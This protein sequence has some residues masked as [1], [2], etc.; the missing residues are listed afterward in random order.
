MLCT[1]SLRALWSLP[2]LQLCLLLFFWL[3]AAS[4]NPSWHSDGVLSL[5]V[6][7]GLAGGSVYV[8]GFKLIAKSVQPETREL[9]MASASVSADIGILIGSVCGLFIQACIFERQGIS[10]AEVDGSYCS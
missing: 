7:A 3:D 10:G 4:T 9:A 6:V 2:L 5:C 1:P 8:H